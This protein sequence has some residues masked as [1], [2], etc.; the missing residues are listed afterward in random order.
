MADRATIIA[1]RGLVDFYFWKGQP[2]A[3]AW[4]KRSTKP[5]TAGEVRSSAAFTA[6]AKWTGAIS[7]NVEAD[8][9]RYIAGTGVTWVDMQRALFRGKPWFR[10]L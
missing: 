1:S 8:Y 5:R 4:P 10:V 7:V 9:R 3:R 6:A 2:V